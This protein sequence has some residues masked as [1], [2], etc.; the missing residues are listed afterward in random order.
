M[1]TYVISKLVS[2]RIHSQHSGQHLSTSQPCSLTP[3]LSGQKK[4]LPSLSQ[5]GTLDLLKVRVGTTHMNVRTRGWS[6]KTPSLRNQPGKP[7]A[8]KTTRK[9]KAALPLTHPDL[10]R[11][12]SRTND[13]YCMIK[14][15]TQ[16]LAGSLSQTPD[17][18]TFLNVKPLVVSNAHTAPGLSQ[19]KEVSPGSAG[20]YCKDCTLRSVKSVSCVTQ[21]S[22]V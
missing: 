5:R 6:T 17:F 16:L 7:L 4:T 15:Q 9:G 2:S 18:L 13:N 20:C 12:S 19:K 1:L 3:P 10:P 21:L 8:R 22:C 14:L 11:A